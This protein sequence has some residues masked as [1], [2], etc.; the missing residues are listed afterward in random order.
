MLLFSSR[1]CYQTSAF[2][3]RW[4]GKFEVSSPKTKQNERKRTKNAACFLQKWNSSQNTVSLYW[5]TVPL[6]TSTIG[7]NTKIRQPSWVGWWVCNTTCPFLVSW[8]CQSLHFPLAVLHLGQQRAEIQGFVL[9]LE[10]LWYQT[11]L[12][13]RR[14]G[15]GLNDFTFQCFNWARCKTAIRD[16]WR[17]LQSA[18]RHGYV[19]VNYSNC[20]R[21]FT[22]GDLAQRNLP[23]VMGQETL[24]SA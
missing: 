11:C 13:L 17:S 20:Y 19:G 4:L 15:L 7:M 3:C 5:R 18:S 1:W 21:L 22:T 14:T 8:C 9:T 12:G 23:E 24:H 10:C 2:C 6:T 16:S